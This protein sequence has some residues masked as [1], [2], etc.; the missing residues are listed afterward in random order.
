MRFSRAVLAEHPLGRP[1]LGT[2]ETV[3]KF[4][5]IVSE[6]IWVLVPRRT[7]LSDRGGKRAHE[8]VLELVERE[9]GD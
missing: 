4:N 7:A 1:I 8:K 6:T 3:R 5:K 2:P 9:F